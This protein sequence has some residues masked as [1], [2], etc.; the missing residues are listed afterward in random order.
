MKRRSVF[1]AAL[2]PIA[3]ALVT[4]ASGETDAPKTVG[5][6][7]LS[8]LWEKVYNLPQDLN[9][10]D[11][12]CTDDF[13]LT[14][15]G[16]DVAMGRVAFKEWARSFSGKIRDIR[17]KSLDMFSS[18]DAKRVVSRWIVTGF[19]GGMFGTAPDNQPIHFTGIAIWEVRD[20]KLAHNWVARSAY[21]LMQRLK[22]PAK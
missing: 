6:K 10:I 19:N 9:A 14:S 20:G 11:R 22:A 4:D 3:C 21:E 13:V 15:S 2:S 12:L 7:L 18:A 16:E 8:E 5:E 17:L 1:A